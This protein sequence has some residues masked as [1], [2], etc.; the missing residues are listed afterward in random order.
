QK[1]EVCS[2]NL[3]RVVREITQYST[4]VNKI[5]HFTVA[6]IVEALQQTTVYPAIKSV[7][8][9]IVYRLL[10]LCDNYCLR[11]LMVAL[12]PATTT[13]LKHLHNNYN[14]YRKFRDAT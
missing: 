3:E 13:L 5:V 12:P 10:D 1:L 2:N 9:S 11:H 4:E 7:I 6:N 8:E 14:T